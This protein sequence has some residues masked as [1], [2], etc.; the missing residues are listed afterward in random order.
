MHSTKLSLVCFQL[1]KQTEEERK[2][3]QTL[4]DFNFIYRIRYMIEFLVINL[5]GISYFFI[6]NNSLGIKNKKIKK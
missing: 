5:Y 2:T 6:Q 1:D 3:L 4:Y